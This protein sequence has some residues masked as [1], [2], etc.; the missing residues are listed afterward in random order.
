LASELE[1]APPRR[2]AT[3]HGVAVGNRGGPVPPLLSFCEAEPDKELWE[4]AA[5][6]T[7]APVY[8][9]C[10]LFTRLAELEHHRETLTS[11]P[12]LP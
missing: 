8:N 12:L 7:V 5:L 4:Y 1:P 6:V 10:N 9:W 11:R 3:P 2:P